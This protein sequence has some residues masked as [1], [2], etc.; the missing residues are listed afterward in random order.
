M[1]VYL[2]GDKK[3][4][5]YP[6][7]SGTA[8]AKGDW[9]YCDA[10]DGF[11]VKP[12]GSFTWNS[13]LAQ[14]QTDFALRFA[15]IADQDY[16]G[17]TFSTAPSQYG[18]QRG[19]I[20]VNQGGVYEEDCASSSTFYPGTLLNCAKQ[21]G[22]LLESSKVVQTFTEVSSTARVWQKVTSASKVKLEI[23]PNL[24]CITTAAD[25]GS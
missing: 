9:L 24:A 16:D 15:G 1:A 21:S 14:T 13:S 19:E 5:P 22:N 17:A 11:A 4:R 6:V 8:I 23:Y 18:L 12:A 3:Q 7:D 20:M 2:H 25:T 10:S